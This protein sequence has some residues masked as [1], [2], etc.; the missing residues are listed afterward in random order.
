MPLT[1][2][3]LKRKRCPNTPVILLCFVIVSL[4]NTVGNLGDCS[5]REY[6]FSKIKIIRLGFEPNHTFVF[7]ILRTL[8]FSSVMLIKMQ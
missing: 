4:K 2:V 7:F 8:Y 1:L 5:L 3:P 6:F